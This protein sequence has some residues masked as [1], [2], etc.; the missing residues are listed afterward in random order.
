MLKIVIIGAGI[1]GLG[2]AY[3]LGELKE[4]IPLEY[5]ILEKDSRPGGLCKTENDNGFLFD[6]TGHLL[7][8]SYDQF[9]QLLI[10]RLKINLLKHLRKSWI[11]SNNVFTQYP[12]QANLYGLPKSIIIECLYDYSKEYFN[13]QKKSIKTFEDWIYKYFGKGISRHFMLPYNTKLFKR[14]PKNLSPDCAGRFVPKPDLKQVLM[15]ALSNKRSNLGYNATFYYPKY[16]GIE[17]IIK[18]ISKEVKRIYTGE[19]V[20]AIDTRTNK[21]QT[22]SGNVFNYDVLISTQPITELSYMLEQKPQFVRDASEKLEYVSVLNINFVVEEDVGDKHWVYVP[23]KKFLFH[24]VGFS[25]NF[26]SNLVPEGLNSIYTEISYLPGKIMDIKEIKDKVIND[27]LTLGIIRQ[28]KSILFDK[29]INI[30]YAYV[31]YNTQRQS[32]LIALHNYLKEKLIFSIGRFGGW[33]Y[34]S[35]EDSFLEGMTTSENIVLR[36]CQ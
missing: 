30:P 31:I 17:T 13:K 5:V 26:S 22:E 12:F 3:K 6:Y 2:A 10:D 33:Q 18:S 27:L 9:K 7:H 11:F 1:T 28:K 24:R 4:Q 15:G 35:M 19:K 29:I 34:T 36:F 20:V 14:H 32:S 23:E 8:F 16:G 21:A 25:S